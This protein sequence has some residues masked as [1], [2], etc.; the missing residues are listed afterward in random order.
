MKEIICELR[1]DI[2]IMKT[3]EIKPNF[4]A[5]AKEH[6]LDYRT[7]KRHYEG[8]DGKPTHHN[9]KSKLIKL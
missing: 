5:L 4:S 8:Y 9:K 2:T 7:V 6:G 1:K 3:M